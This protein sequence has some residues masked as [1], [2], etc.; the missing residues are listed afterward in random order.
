VVLLDDCV[1]ENDQL[2][3]NAVQIFPTESVANFRVV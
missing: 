3:A 1:A 2:A